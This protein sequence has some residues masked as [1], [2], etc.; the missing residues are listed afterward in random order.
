MGEV[1]TK[2][3]ERFEQNLSMV[4]SRSAQVDLCIGLIRNS[5]DW[6]WKH[7]VAYFPK[8][9]QILYSD[10]LGQLQDKIVVRFALTI[11]HYSFDTPAFLADNNKLLSK[12]WP[13][14]GESKV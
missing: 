6:L 13:D 10:R 2:P 8:D 7:M 11:Y 1:R 14:N 3:E 4:A 5:A 9:Q 12:D